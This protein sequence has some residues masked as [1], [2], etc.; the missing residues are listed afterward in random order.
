MSVAVAIP[1][2]IDILVVKYMSAIFGKGKTF[3]LGF[4][5]AS[6]A[7]LLDL[8]IAEARKESVH[9]GGSGGNEQDGNCARREAAI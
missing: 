8:Q 4:V 9:F 3:D 6:R 1:V 5:P 7:S 2:S